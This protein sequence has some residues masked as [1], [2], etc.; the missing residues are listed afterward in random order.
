MKKKVIAQNL[1]SEAI[2]QA[3][4]A[5]MPEGLAPVGVV[6]SLLPRPHGAPLARTGTGCVHEYDLTSEVVRMRRVPRIF[7]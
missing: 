4:R 7:I 5:S 6:W 3:R 2:N 1:S